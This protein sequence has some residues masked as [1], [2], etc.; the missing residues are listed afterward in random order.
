MFSLISTFAICACTLTQTHTYTHVQVHHIVS[1]KACAVVIVVPDRR[2]TYVTFRG[3]KDPVD[4]LTDINF[5]SATFTPL[6]WD[7]VEEE[8]LGTTGGGETTG[9]SAAGFLPFIDPHAAHGQLQLMT[10]TDDG[11]GALKVHGGFKIAFDSIKDRV[12][13]LLETHGANE[14]VVFVGHSMG[15]ALAQLATVYYCELKARLVTF[16]S[17]AIG[18]GAFCRLLD[19][20]G[21][22]Y[23]GLRVWNDFD[24]VPSIAQLV[25]YKHAGVPIKLDVSKSAKELFE[26]ENV[27]SL[28]GLIDLLAPHVMFQLGSVCFVFPVIGWDLQSGGTAMK[29][30]AAEQ[31]QQQQEQQT[32][33]GQGQGQGGGKGQPLIPAL[34]PV[35]VESGASSP[36]PP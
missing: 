26:E 31:Q 21:Q 20:C 2:T 25:G 23:G 27:N 7:P 33:N 15:G 8:D 29:R 6:G 4:V 13:D 30:M 11:T 18:N 19:C 35:V 36:P 28:K 5:L 22:P 10:G 16:A 24:V 32:K 14:N 1:D 3:T 9:G 17:P 34:Q 12:T